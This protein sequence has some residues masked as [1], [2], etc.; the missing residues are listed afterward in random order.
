MGKTLTFKDYDELIGGLINDA[1]MYIKEGDFSKGS[2][3]LDWKSGSN[4]SILFFVEPLWEERK[5]I[6]SKAELTL[7]GLEDIKSSKVFKAIDKYL[8]DYGITRKLKE[9]LEDNI[10]LEYLKEIAGI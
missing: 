8:I 6:I 3:L 10:E 7:S 5:I 4:V 9:C 2:I 1:K